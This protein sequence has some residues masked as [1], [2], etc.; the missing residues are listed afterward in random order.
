[1]KLFNLLIIG[2]EILSG[3]RKDCHLEN[4][5]NLLSIRGFQ[6]N[7]SLI[8]GDEPGLIISSLRY[9]AK[10]QSVVFCCGGI[11]A[12]PDDY[13]RQCAADAF[14]LKLVRHSEATRL[15]EEQFA[16]GAYPKRIL[17][18]DLP[19]N[20]SLIPNPV[21]QVPGFSVGDC[22][23]V[24]GFPQM[25]K[26]MMEWVLDSYYESM[27]PSEPNIEKSA[28]VFDQPESELIDLM[29]QILVKYPEVKLASLPKADERHSR[30]DLAIKGK[31]KDVETA[32]AFL[33]A[34]LDRESIKY[35]IQ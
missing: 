1:M 29:N 25:A 19:E 21:N 22:H 11:G 34:S 24:P 4:M 35:K 33:L 31:S 17:M 28:W 23:F 27:R 12:T 8:I 13:T 26:P 9:L 6:L 16:D 3:K 7:Q 2:D 20:A 30:I 18:A 5:I 10:D 15:I 14:S 32:F